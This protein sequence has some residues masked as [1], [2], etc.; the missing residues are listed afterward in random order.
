[1]ETK[2][3]QN[4][5][6]LERLTLERDSEREEFE[7]DIKSMKD[8]AKDRERDIFL[9]VKEKFKTEVIIFLIRRSHRTWN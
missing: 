4:Q 6:N 5:K 1:L 9:S 2:L 7:K 8:Y 3:E